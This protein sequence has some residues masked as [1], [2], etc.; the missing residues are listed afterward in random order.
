M[1]VFLNDRCR[2]LTPEAGGNLHGSA[3]A[4][5]KPSPLLQNLLAQKQHLFIPTSKETHA[6]GQTLVIHSIM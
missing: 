6:A 1:L 2:W 5:G 4:N 3:L